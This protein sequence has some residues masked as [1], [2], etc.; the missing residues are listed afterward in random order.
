MPAVHVWL[1]VIRGNQGDEVLPA[2]WSDNALTLLPGELREVIVRFRP[3]LLAAAPPHLMAEGW[4]VTPRE[5]TVNDGC[6]VPLAMQ[7]TG[8]EVRREAGIVKLQFEATQRGA[9]GPR[10]TTWPTPVKVD[11]NIVR[12]VRIG[13]RSGVTSS[14]IVTLVNLPV[15]KHRI[16]VGDGAETW[17]AC[18]QTHSRNASADRD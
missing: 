7:V 3:N 5:W 18:G 8:C 11:G 9:E 12:Y 17:V 1:E 16:S 10:W 6:A 14:A 4:N 13:L 2:F 15:G